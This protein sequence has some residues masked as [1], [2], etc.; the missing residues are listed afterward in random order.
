MDCLENPL[1]YVTLHKVH[2]SF[3]LKPSYWRSRVYK[4]KF[5]NFVHHHFN[6]YQNSNRTPSTESRHQLFSDKH[7]TQCWCNYWTHIKHHCYVVVIS[8]YYETTAKMY[9]AKQYSPMMLYSYHEYL[10][11]YWWNI[12]QYFRKSKC[13]MYMGSNASPAQAPTLCKEHTGNTWNH[14]GR[15]MAF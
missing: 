14:L 1:A 13:S 5:C 6:I 4:S 11:N 12:L 7:L 2:F 15:L 10:Q 9:L 3:S 8:K